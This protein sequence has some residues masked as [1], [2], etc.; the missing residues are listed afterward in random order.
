[1]FITFSIA[2]D[3]SKPLVCSRTDIDNDETKTA[4][5]VDNTS[6][7]PEMDLDVKVSYLVI[8]VK[9][10]LLFINLYK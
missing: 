1:M 5:Y 2:D 8:N 3:G 9:L 10:V 4:V 6:S 7:E